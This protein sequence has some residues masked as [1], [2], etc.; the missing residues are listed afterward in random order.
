MTNIDR[1]WKSKDITLL[2]KVRIVKAM[3]FPVVMY[4]HESWTMKKAECQRNDAFKLWCWRRLSR[5]P[6]TSRR[7]NQSIP[8]SEKS[9]LNTHWEDWRGSWSSNT[10][11]TWCK[12]LTHWKDSDTGKGWSQRLR[13]RQRMSWLD[14]ITN[15]MDVNLGKLREMGRDREA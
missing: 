6:W 11:A 1:A 8:V 10:L 12:E 15:S 13:G 7:W 4:R 2:T 9:T 14:G 5:V 3:I